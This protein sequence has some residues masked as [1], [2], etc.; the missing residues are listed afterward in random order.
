MFVVFDQGLDAVKINWL[1]V[2]QFNVNPLTRQT[3]FPDF[4]KW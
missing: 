3:V 4:V 1:G 2:F